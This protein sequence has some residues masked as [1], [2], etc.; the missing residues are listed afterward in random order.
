[1]MPARPD[2]RDR[3]T[4]FG[5]L[6]AMMRGKGPVI[7]QNRV[8]SGFWGSFKTMWMIP[9]DYDDHHSEQ[10]AVLRSPTS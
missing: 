3:R 2:P 10:C 7:S 1:M 6:S 5:G 8:R 4:L 9:G